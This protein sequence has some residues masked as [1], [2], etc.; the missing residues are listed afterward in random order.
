LVEDPRIADRAASDRD[1]V[2]TRIVNHVEAGLSVEKVAAA[3]HDAVAG[4]LF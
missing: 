2:D 4:V 3:E 1:P